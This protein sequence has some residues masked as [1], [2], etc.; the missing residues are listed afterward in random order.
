MPFGKSKMGKIQT[1]LAD[2]HFK[3]IDL[4]TGDFKNSVIFQRQYSECPIKEFVCVIGAN[5]KV[6]YCHDKAYM[7]NGK[8]CD[9]AQASFKECWYS[10]QV[11]SLFQKFDAKKCCKQHCVYDSRNEL[12]NSFIWIGTMLTLYSEAA[13]IWHILI[14]SNRCIQRQ[15]EIIRSV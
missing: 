11:D 4:Y 1:E 13:K 9:I 7:S 3:I 2:E 14:S 12:I 10:E 8:V 6:Y 15:K 5:A